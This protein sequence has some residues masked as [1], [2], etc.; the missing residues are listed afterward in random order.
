MRSP[1][2]VP[3]AAF[4][5]F[6]GATIMVRTRIA[7]SKDVPVGSGRC[8]SHLFLEVFAPVDVTSHCGHW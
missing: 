3:F 5:T 2:G 8:L 1:K 4:G 6:C 7:A